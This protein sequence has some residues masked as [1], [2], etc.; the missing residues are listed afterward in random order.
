MPEIVVYT[1]RYCPF[2][3]RA[4]NLLNKKGVGYKEIR[5]DINPGLRQEMEIKSNRESVPQIFIGS[6][7]VGGCDDMYALEAK[8]L[9]DKILGLK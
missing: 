6:Q 3:V 8:G 2:C 9:L 5:I 4:I 7:H 1:T